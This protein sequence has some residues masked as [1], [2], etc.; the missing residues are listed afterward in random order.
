MWDEIMKMNDAE[1]AELVGGW[2]PRVREIRLEMFSNLVTQLDDYWDSVQVD[3]GFDARVL[4]DT[5]DSHTP[6]RTPLTAKHEQMKRVL[7]V[8][9]QIEGDETNDEEE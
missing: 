4:A 1:L 9:R 6:H 8:L 7:V 5:L 3:F 2:S